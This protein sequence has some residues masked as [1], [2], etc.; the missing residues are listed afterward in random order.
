[1]GIVA[2]SLPLS[3]EGVGKENGFSWSKVGLYTQGDDEIRLEN[4]EQ[5]FPDPTLDI[6]TVT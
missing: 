5:Q 3:L 2:V 4:H 6:S 1:M